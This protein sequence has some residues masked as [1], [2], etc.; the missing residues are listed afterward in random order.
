MS[1]L[2]IGLASIVLVA[3][4]G[5]AML[6]NQ[7]P[8]PSH[9]PQSSSATPLASSPEPQPTPRATVRATPIPLPSVSVCVAPPACGRDV[10]PSVCLPVPVPTCH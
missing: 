9:A 5:A 7:S 2:L 4:V 8:T 3:R 10:P 1:R 6:P